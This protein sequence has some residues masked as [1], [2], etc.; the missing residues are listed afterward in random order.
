MEPAPE[1]LALRLPRMVAGAG[2]P[3]IVG[4]SVSVRCEEAVRV[5]GAEP[6]GDDLERGIARIEA[7]LAARPRRARGGANEV[8][9]P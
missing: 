5:A 3:V 8:T 6:V 1:L 9:A 7:L 4:G 2:V